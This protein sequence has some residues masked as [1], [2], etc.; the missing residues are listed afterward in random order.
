VGPNDGHAGF[1][2]LH[3]P[4]LVSKI[5]VRLTAWIW[6]KFTEWIRSGTICEVKSS[7][8]VSINFERPT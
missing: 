6:C 5:G 8:C 1:R 7:A 2:I 4:N 3:V